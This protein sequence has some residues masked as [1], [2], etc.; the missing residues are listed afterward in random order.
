MSNPTHNA[1]A[2]V[3]RGPPPDRMHPVVRAMMGANPDPTT[4]RE[5]LAVQRDWEAGEARREFAVARV[6]LAAALPTVIRQDVHV[7]FLQTDF[8]HSSLAEIVSTVVP[9]LAAH[10]F[11]VAWYPKTD[12]LHVEVV[13]RLSHVGGHAEEAAI[14]EEAENNPKSPAKGIL[15]TITRLRRHTLVAL[16]G[17]STGDLDDADDAPPPQSSDGVSSARNLKAV[18]ALKKYG[19]TR[20]QAEAHTGRKVADWTSADLDKLKAWLAPASAPPA[21]TTALD[22][23]PPPSDEYESRPESDDGEEYEPLHPDPTDPPVK[24]SVVTTAP[25]NSPV[26]TGQGAGEMPSMRAPAPTNAQPAP[27]PQRRGHT[28][29]DR[30]LAEFDEF[31][32]HC[33]TKSEL[34]AVAKAATAKL[35]EPSKKIARG[36]YQKHARRIDG[37]K[38]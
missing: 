16:L 13:C 27:M 2:I 3:E 26:H 36:I 34:D 8:W 4:L 28:D 35:P 5:L 17:L 7:K 1:V 21:D 11:A 29:E 19:R 31:A 15:G 12:N 6:E 32:G 20:E 25:Q 14:A 9:I 10:G 24:Q 38:K 33:R 37:D 23:E 30:Y 18:A 22:N